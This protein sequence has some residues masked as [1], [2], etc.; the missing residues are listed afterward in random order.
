ME[1]TEV[2]QDEWSSP[3]DVQDTCLLHGKSIGIGGKVKKRGDLEKAKFPEFAVRIE[4]G[5]EVVA[6][7]WSQDDV[8]SFVDVRDA[9]FPPLDGLGVGIEARKRGEF[10]FSNSPLF[11][12][13]IPTPKPSKGKKQASQ[14]STKLMMLS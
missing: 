7:D 5:E 13:S 9:R 6:K 4:E 8:I 10:T 1:L 14:V 11:L 12:A 3:P 2:F